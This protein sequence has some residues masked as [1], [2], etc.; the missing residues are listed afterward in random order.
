MHLRLMQ[1]ALSQEQGRT[2]HHC[3]IADHHAAEHFLGCIAK[4]FDDDFRTDARSIAQRD[5]HG[6]DQMVSHGHA[7]LSMSMNSCVMPS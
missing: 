7:G 5:G 6:L 2:L 4:C 3:H 1:L